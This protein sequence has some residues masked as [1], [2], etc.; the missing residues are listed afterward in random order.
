MEGINS[1]GRRFV[2][3]KIHEVDN[4]LWIKLFLQLALLSSIITGEMLYFNP[5]F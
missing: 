3:N 1:S 4:S 5:Y 2:A